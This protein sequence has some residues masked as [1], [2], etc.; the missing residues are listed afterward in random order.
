MRRSNAEIIHG[1]PSR[2]QDLS[3]R[4]NNSSS[5]RRALA[6]ISCIADEAA[7]PSGLTITELA[8]SLDMNRST[9][10]RLLTP[11]CN[12]QFIERDRDTSRYRLGS[13]TAY[14]AEIYLE[15]L[16]LRK[17]A[18]E[19]LV[20]LRDT[21]GETVHLVIFEPPEVVYVDKIES[22]KPV[23]MCSR[24]GRRQPAYSTGAGK[25]FLAYASEEILQN[26]LSVGLSAHTPNTITSEEALRA[27]LAKIRRRGY[28]IDNIENEPDIR[29]LGCPIFDHTGK[30][31][32]AASVAGPANRVTLSRISELSRA[33]TATC[34]EISRRLGY[35]QIS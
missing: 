24:I 1:D 30:V 17:A 31:I 5:L 32:A 22:P 9:V 19:A 14:L 15:R 4:R 2:R 34:A 25:A 7:D 33:V 23:R 29:C 21:S 8:R 26:V 27:E 28:A 18:H 13:R 3:G 16:D 6:I 11:L 35:R 10:L 20:K 12:E